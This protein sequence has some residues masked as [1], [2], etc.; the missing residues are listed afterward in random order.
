VHQLPQPDRGREPHG[1]DGEHLLPVP[2]PRRGGGPRD[3]PDRGCGEK[4][5]KAPEKDI[6]YGSMTFTTRISS[7]RGTSR[8]RTA[9]STR[10]RERRSEEGACFQCHNDEK[11]LARFTD[12][13]FMHKQHVTTRRSTACI[14]T[15]D[16]ARREDEHR[17]A[18]FRLQR[19]P[20]A[21]AQYP[22]Q[23]YQGIGARGVPNRPSRC[24]R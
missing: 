15:S 14:A 12:I 2:L 17:A 9:T 5:H 4:C 3:E 10:S 1:G 6:K 20:R 16:Q 24:S 18:P 8:A 11:R 19:L 7:G 22:E 13:D 21:Q 23:I